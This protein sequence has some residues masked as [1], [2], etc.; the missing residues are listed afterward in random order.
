MKKMKAERR[1]NLSFNPTYNSVY[2][3]LNT[4]LCKFSWTWKHWLGALLFSTTVP[5]VSVFPCGWDTLTMWNTSSLPHP[6]IIPT[7]APVIPGHSGPA[8][9]VSEQL[10]VAAEPTFI[11]GDMPCTMIPTAN[12]SSYKL[13]SIFWSPQSWKFMHT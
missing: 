13:W 9:I 1:I 6:Y 8:W 4:Q 2:F 12:A 11:N 5:L 10:F 7:Q 3:E